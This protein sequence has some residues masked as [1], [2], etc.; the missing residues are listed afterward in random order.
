MEEEEELK[1]DRFQCMN[2]LESS[3]KCAI[4][5]EFL[6]TP[7][8][9]KDCFHVYCSICIRRWYQKSDKCPSCPTRVKSTNSFINLKPLVPFLQGW[10]QVKS[11]SA[12]GCIATSEKSVCPL[13]NIQFAGKEQ[14]KEHVRDCSGEAPRIPEPT[15]S[16]T[17]EKPAE[18]QSIWFK[19]MKDTQVRSKLHDL[20]LRTHGSRQVLED[21]YREYAVRR[22]ATVDMWK[23]LGY[24]KKE[25]VIRREIVREEDSFIRGQKAEARLGPLLRGSQS[26]ASGNDNPSDDSFQAL[27]DRARST[28]EKSRK[29]PRSASQGSNFAT[30]EQ[31]TQNSKELKPDC[32]LPDPPVEVPKTELIDITDED[33]IVV[34]EDT[35]QKVAAAAGPGHERLSPVR[36][37]DKLVGDGAPPKGPALSVED[38]QINKSEAGPG[39]SPDVLK[40]IALHREAALER[41][42]RNAELR[43]RSNAS[44]DQP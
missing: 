18:M 23:Q 17:F 20:G 15:E 24:C 26:Q 5:K 32:G 4:C 35:D 2:R 11:L 43:K 7:M 12:M 22:N 44:K 41:Q 40:R 10:Q 3:L 9:L 19:G 36:E 30:S 14:L 21:R 31:G 1:P 28:M 8:M 13:C 34:C 29:R 16:Y 6:E 42:R 37:D 39:L 33:M 38:E 27:I 25:D